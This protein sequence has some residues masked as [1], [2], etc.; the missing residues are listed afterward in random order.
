VP[1]VIGLAVLAAFIF[2]A[3][4][5][6]QQRAVRSMADIAPDELVAQRRSRFG[7]IF[8]ALPVRHFLRSLVTNRLWLMGWGLNLVGFCCQAAAL[9]LGSVALVQPVLVTQLLFALPLAAAWQRRKPKPRD[10]LAAVGICGGVAL[11]LSV[12]GAAPLRGEPDR[13][14]VLLATAC[15]MGL[16]LLLALSARSR[17]PVAH[18]TLVAIAAGLCFA[19]SAVFLKLTVEL[20]LGP[21]VAATA[22]DWPGYA[23]AG[24]TFLGLLLEQEAFAAGSLAGAIAAMTITNPVASYLIGVLAFQV[25]LPGSPGV[26]AAVTGSA[27]LIAFGAVG[28]ANSDLVREAARPQ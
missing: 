9:Y 14:K 1:L 27:V 2:A 23:L 24:S 26:L 25:P 19:L 15:A 6:L 11:F 4:A 10:W 7:Q 13:F 22:T 16:A 12:R 21:G 18:A 20:L 17:P 3:A 5:S 28:L 8:R